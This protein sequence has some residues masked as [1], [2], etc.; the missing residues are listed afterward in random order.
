MERSS[1]SMSLGLVLLVCSVMM[2][3]LMG[4]ASAMLHVVGGRQGW[5]VPDNVTFYQDWAKPRTF[6]VGDQLIFPY[7]PG[8]NNL[9][10]INKE[11]YETCDMRSPIESYYMGPTII[12]LKHVGDYYFVA[13]SGRHCEF[14]QRLHI[15]VKKAPGSSGAKFPIK[16][17]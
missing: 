11:A 16:H 1:S 5:D 7:R 8:S 9:L 17:H 3:M 12:K 13:S 15:T 6:G 2:A 10:V 14:G 4:S